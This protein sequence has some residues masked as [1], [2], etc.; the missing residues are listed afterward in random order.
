MSYFWL[1]LLHLIYLRSYSYLNFFQGAGRS[2]ARAFAAL[3]YIVLALS[4][5]MDDILGKYKVFH[6]PFQSLGS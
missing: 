4:G 6:H 1:Y 3:K 2:V 5:H